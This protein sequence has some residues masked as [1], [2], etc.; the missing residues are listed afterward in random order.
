MS[1]WDILKTHILDLMRK[2]S[3]CVKFPFFWTRKASL[4]REE[5]QLTSVWPTG[6]FLMPQEVLLHI[7]Y[8]DIYTEDSCGVSEFALEVFCIPHNSAHILQGSLDYLFGRH[9]TMQTYGKF[10]RFPINSALFGL[11]I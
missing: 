1:R 10:E 6:H 11:V 7:I 9:Q 2:R 4:L 8:T 3:F 5:H